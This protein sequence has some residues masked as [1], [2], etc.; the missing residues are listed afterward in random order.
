M[1]LS[2]KV[3]IL[4]LYSRIRSFS[5]ARG[6]ESVAYFGVG[7][8]PSLRIRDSRGGGS[9]VQAGK[10]RFVFREGFFAFAADRNA[11]Y[12]ILFRS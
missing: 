2:L 10:W 1:T 6:G 7:D 9:T 4:F 12:N 5:Y 8:K 3:H 11:V